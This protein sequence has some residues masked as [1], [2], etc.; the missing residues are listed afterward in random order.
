[1]LESGV[2]AF[3]RRHGLTFDGRIGPATRRALDVTPAERLRQIDLGLER[4]RRMPAQRG[5]RH[6][7]VNIPSAE[8]VAYERGEERLRM[9]VVTGQPNWKTPVFSE[10]IVKLKFAPTWTIPYKL[11]PDHIGRA[12]CR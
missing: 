2:K 7:I 4:L 8:L 3:Q 6:I 9:P 5:E 10:E 11:I 12:C 1:M